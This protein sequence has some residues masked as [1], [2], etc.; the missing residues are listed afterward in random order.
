MA[1]DGGVGAAVEAHGDRVGSG[2]DL[3]GGFQEAA[4]QDV[5]VTVA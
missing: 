5:G 3:A 2:D 4:L 1:Q